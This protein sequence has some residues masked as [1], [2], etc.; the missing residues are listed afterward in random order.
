MKEKHVKP[1]F[2]ND[3]S[4]FGTSRAFI[5]YMNLE[6]PFS[7]TYRN[8]TSL[9]TIGLRCLCWKATMSISNDKLTPRTNKKLTFNISSSSAS[10]C[11]FF[12]VRMICLSLSS[13]SSH[14]SGEGTSGI[15]HCWDGCHGSGLWKEQSIMN[16]VRPFCMALTVRL[17]YDFPSL[18]RS[19][20]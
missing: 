11:G 18:T 15:G 1:T 5:Q 12:S 2:W 13:S 10:R 9:M 8:F 14:C 16:T 19:T 7:S 6:I 17:T 20:W 4:Y 3:D